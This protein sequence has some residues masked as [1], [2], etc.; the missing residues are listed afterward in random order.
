MVLFAAAILASAEDGSICPPYPP[1]QG[2]CALAW[3]FSPLLYCAKNVGLLL[4]A[5]PR[6]NPLPPPETFICWAPPIRGDRTTLVGGGICRAASAFLSATYGTPAGDRGEAPSGPWKK[7]SEEC[8]APKPRLLV[9]GNRLL[10]F[11]PLQSIRAKHDTTDSCYEHVTTL[12]KSEL[13]SK[14]CFIEAQF[15]VPTFLGNGREAH[16]KTPPNN[17]QCDAPRTQE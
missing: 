16:D 14:Q 2:A 5:W 6:S 3:P 13:R 7:K 4:S 8:L 12:T 15:A 9:K 1:F 10:S 17:L 11:Q